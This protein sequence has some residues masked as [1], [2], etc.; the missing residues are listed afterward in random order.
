MAVCI[1]TGFTVAA[2]VAMTM[3]MQHVVTHTA[4]VRELSVMD[5][6]SRVTVICADKT[7]TLT[8]DIKKPISVYTGND[9]EELT[10][11]P[12]ERTQALIRMATL[13]TANDTQTT[14]IDNHLLQNPTESAIIEYARDIGIERR[15]L[16]EENPRLAELPFDASRRCMSVVHLVDGKRLMV[17]MGAPEKVL[18]LCT[19]GPV[20]NAEEVCQQLGERSLRVLAIAYKMVD[21]LTASELDPSLESDMYFAGLIGLAD[22]PRVES[23]QSIRECAQS[24]IITVMITGDNESTA[25]AVGLQ[26]GILES[27]D[28][29]LTG[30]EL[31]KMD[32]AELDASVGLYRVFARILPEEK[33]RIIKAWQARG[34]VVASTGNCL[35]DVPAL[36]SADIGCATGA[37]DCDMTRN[38]SDLTLYDNSFA[39]LVDAIKHARGIYANISKVI[40]YVLSC[41]LTVMLA[42]LLALLFSPG[43][44]VLSPLSTVFYMIIGVLCSLAISY[45]SG[46][47]HSLNQKPRR[48]LARL[49]PASAWISTLWQGILTGIL[50]FIAFYAGQAG[51]SAEGN[52]LS[53]GM[54]TAFIMLILS[55]LWMVL[56]SHR[57]DPDRPKIANRVMPIVLLVCIALSAILLY[58]PIVR[59]LFGL[60]VVSSSNWVLA[61]ILSAITPIAV[62]VVRFI[63]I[64]ISTVKSNEAA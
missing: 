38:E 59:E 54:T 56:A 48:G 16:M 8:A 22:Q 26:L 52:D 11:M 32:K 64:I 43:D 25:Y 30:E 50:A 62:I 47:R 24:G 31:R 2:V 3:G 46:D 4:D 9:I 5:T 20:Q 57:H 6:L 63:S 49:V 41:S 17:T 44:F 55:R 14:G 27:E 39:T 33:E 40:Q 7:G 60:T 1:P 34:A 12:G 10:R 58:V 15:L 45:E 35:E 13:C 51:T 18:S 42:T 37:A 36:Q 28:Q 21:E 23:I 61:L 53:V 29:V 19:Y